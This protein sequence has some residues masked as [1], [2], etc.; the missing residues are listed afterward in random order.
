MRPDSSPADQ[1]AARPLRYVAIGD[2]LTEG[3]G[4]DP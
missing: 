3:V 1:G 4:D 2:S